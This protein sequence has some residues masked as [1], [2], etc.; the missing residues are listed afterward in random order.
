MIPEKATKLNS[1]YRFQKKYA[2]YG[3]IIGLMFPLMGTMIECRLRFG[4]FSL[5]HFH[6]CQMEDPLLWIIDTAPLVL[7]IFAAFAGRQMDIIRLIN[8]EL[9]DKYIQMN[10]LRQMADSSN[11]AKGDFLAT[12]SHE[13]RTPISAII[14]YNNLLMETNLTREQEDLAETIKI[15]TN[16]LHILINDILDASRLEAGKVELEGKD[17]NLELLVNNLVRLCRDRAISKNLRIIL[18]FDASLPAYL[19]GDETRISQI[20]L[21]LIGNAIKFTKEGK[22][23]LRVGLA[24]QGQDSVDV[25]FSVIDTGIGISKENLNRIFERFSQAEVWTNRL[26]GGTGLGLHIVKSLVDLH[27][28]KIEVNSVPGKGSEFT[29][30][31]PLRFGTSPA[32]SI[33]ISNEAE[34]LKMPLTGLRILIAEDN[35]FNMF[36]AE[37]YLKR[38]G[39]QL[40]KVADGRAA[41]EKSSEMDFDVILMDIQMPLLDGK[42]AT[43]TI[44]NKGLQTPIVGCSAHALPAEK[45]ECLALGM[46]AYISK[47]YEEKQ[48]ISILTELGGN[49]SKQKSITPMENLNS[50]KVDEILAAIKADVGP[51]FVAIIIQKFNADIPVLIAE[52]KQHRLEKDFKTIQEKIHKLAGTMAT[53][54]FQEGL[55]LA[56]AAEFAARDGME[57]ETFTGMD[58]LESYL[59]DTLRK[60]N[61]YKVR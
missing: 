40:E 42:E 25:Q 56:R 27:K 57:V 29:V 38:N 52:L 23:E 49:A 2:V 48:L 34:S 15:A 55:R 51:D 21:N 50:E 58:I 7:A 36:L 37:T 6:I 11:Q 26:Y 19:K 39:A 44:R 47:P 41:V 14:G 9:N 17:F 32:H 35:E 22:V 31:L 3:A 4:F 30:I 54:R 13:I 45:A 24:A 59:L 16:S 53:F 12:M 61:E 33:K 10:V 1:D 8:N 18:N 28:G 20:L 43:R 60:I 5:S 46:N